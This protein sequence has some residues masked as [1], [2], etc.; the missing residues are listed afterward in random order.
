MSRYGSQHAR[1]LSSVL[2]RR[3]DRPDHYGEHGQPSAGPTH[4]A[5]PLNRSLLQVIRSDVDLRSHAQV[6]VSCVV[7]V[8]H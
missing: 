7:K 3:L 8:A 2:I 5:L 6:S 1:C 4:G